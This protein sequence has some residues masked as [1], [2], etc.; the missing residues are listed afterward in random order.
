MA[1]DATIDDL[2]FFRV[3]KPVAEDSS[4]SYAERLS[5]TAICGVHFGVDQFELFTVKNGKISDI[6]VC[7][8]NLGEDHLSIGA[9]ARKRGLKYIAIW[10][11]RR[12]EVEHIRRL[13]DTGFI[14][15]DVDVAVVSAKAPQV[16]P[17]GD[18][19]RMYVL[20]RLGKE[21]WIAVSH[22]RD[23]LRQIL[24]I[25]EKSGITVVGMQSSAF[26]IV[27]RMLHDHPKD[28]AQVAV[29]RSGV[30]C[31]NWAENEL[32]QID[33]VRF[34]A[35]QSSQVEQEIALREFWPEY[36]EDKAEKLLN[37]TTNDL[38]GNT[39]EGSR[40]D[41]GWN[42]GYYDI[43]PIPREFA[44][45]MPRIGIPIVGGLWLGMIIATFG[46]VYGFWAAGGYWLAIKSNTVERDTIIA[47][48][49]EKGAIVSSFEA[50]VS[51]ANRIGRWVNRN[52]RSS[53]I[54]GAV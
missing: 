25:V 17:K 23:N 34:T 14:P 31:L 20:S 13:K 2:L 24:E 44:D 22:S 8:Y 5:G 3:F 38:I 12:F 48:V 39:W 37:P 27:S 6:D 54:V 51:Y 35:I 29:N 7:G 36:E 1:E 19:T 33:G 46:I 21:D 40:F 9:Y 49:Q 45:K 4:V 10:D 42:K 50:D 11:G 18:A 26:S 47:Q 28:G 15:D 16:I 53:E 32:L 43:S 30:V 52:V 41:G